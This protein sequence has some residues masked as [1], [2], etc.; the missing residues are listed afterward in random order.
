[1][2]NTLFLPELREMLAAANRA[3]LEEFCQA[4]NAGRT[5]EFM[6]GLADDEVWQVLQFA[7]PTRRAE[8]FG[9]FPHQRK[10]T[11][12][13]QSPSAQAAELIEELPS[14][15]RVDLIQ[16]MSGQRA[17]QIMPLLPLEDRRDIQRLQSYPDETAGALMTSEVA[18]LEEHLTVR[19]ALEELGRQSSELETIYYLYVVDDKNLL[20][21]VVSTRQLVSSLKTPT[22]TLG[23]IMESDVIAALVSDDQETVA[24]RVE[25]F[26]LLAIP[27]VDSGRQLLGIIT[28]DDVIDVVREEL[29]EDAQRIAAVEP[30][31]GNFLKVGLWTL[32]WKRGLWLTILFF[33]ALLT[34]FALRH[35]EVELD[36]FAWL[37]WFIPLIISAGGNSGSQSATLVITA[38]TSGEVK[39]RDWPEV[40]RREVIV[41][42]GLGSFLAMIGF[43]V[44]LFIAPSP[45][46][47]MVIPFTLLSVIVCGC[48]CGATLPIV[49]KRL[50]LDPAMMSNPFVAGIVDILGIVIYINIARAL[51]G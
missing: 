10:L 31:E 18:M 8:I 26:N 33:A 37:V 4:L 35:Y 19:E 2:Y 24:E 25:R 46:A 15:D 40:L 47:A 30:L 7:D 28:H 1:M 49:F 11:L 50:G 20:R 13:E 38:M 23:E 27:V 48:L 34:A 21:G 36:K 9:Y 17:D 51:L 5:A 6:E 12:L 44:A 14:D 45:R 16:E 32:S 42:F 22:R 39:F 43:A 29:A 3:E 41:A